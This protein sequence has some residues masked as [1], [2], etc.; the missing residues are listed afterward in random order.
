MRACSETNLSIVVFQ[1]QSL[2]REVEGE[3]PQYPF[4][5]LSM[6][7]GEELLNFIPLLLESPRSLPPL[8]PL[9]RILCVD[10]VCDDYRLCTDLAVSAHVHKSNKL[11]CQ[12]AVN[13]DARRPPNGTLRLRLDTPLGSSITGLLAKL[14]AQSGET[15]ALE[16]TTWGTGNHNLGI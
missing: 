12:G 1:L 5:L 4:T 14:L 15:W 11:R 2:R 8:D 10:E 6:R 7:R 9:L 16:T 13:Y 3:T